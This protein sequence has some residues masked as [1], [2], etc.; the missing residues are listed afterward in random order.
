MKKI[1]FVILSCM[2]IFSLGSIVSAKDTGNGSDEF[3]TGLEEMTDEELEA[4]H[5]TL[6]RIVDVK[7]NSIALSRL[8]EDEIL[9][10]ENI[11]VAELGEEMVYAMPGEEINLMS[12]SNDSWLDEAVDVSKAATFPPIG[13]QG[14]FA[15][16]L[17]WTLCY[18]QLT[19]NN[20][21]VNGLRAKTEFGEAIPEN[22]MAPGFIFTL[23]NGGRNSGANF[24]YGLNAIMSFGC[25][26]ISHY[27]LEIT[28]E[29]LKKWC[30][31]TSV[32]YNAIYNRP[33]KFSFD[34]ISTSGIVNAK[35]DCVKNIKKIISNGYVVS[36]GTVAKA[37]EF[38]GN[39]INGEYACRYMNSQKIEENEGHAMTVVGYDDNYWVDVNGN[40]KEDPG[41]IGAFKIAN[42]WGFDSAQYPQGYAWIAYD[43]LGD[44]SGVANAPTNR[45]GAMG[46]YYYFIEPQKNYAPLLVA[47]LELTAMYRDNVGI[48]F[49]VS[50]IDNNLAA[51]NPVSYNGMNMPFYFATYYKTSGNVNFSGLENQQETVKIPFDLTPLIK[52]T[53]KNKEI[54]PTKDLKVSV[55]VYDE[56]S[57]M[58]TVMLGY[59]KILEPITGKKVTCLDA[60][61]IV[62]GG[63]GAYKCV[64]FEIT[65]IVSF[66]NQKSVVII[67]NSNICKESVEGNIDVITPD[68]E[69]ICPKYEVAG[70]EIIL[71]A[72]SGGYDYDSKYEIHISENINSIG[73]N[74][75]NFENKIPVYIHSEYFEFKYIN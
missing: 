16:C 34:E 48:E 2:I 15:S 35:S 22:I 31:D 7:P 70:K 51:T 47:E 27:E 8:S 69:I 4:F 12:A 32:W 66:D 20:C 49:K 29:S 37:F 67:F 6:P 62:A 18:Y 9:L 56:S 36:F 28:N 68:G 19:N 24:E 38:T 73:G 33:A 39:P 42:S 14:D 65:P 58:F 61:D 44:V 3:Y 50:D 71:F 72:P 54:S 21:V 46:Q 60:S 75:L 25:P 43:A 10:L 5:S 53:Y 17:T 63:D 11:E 23:L 55:Y 57:G 59:V 40:Q 45:I 64:D 1:I 41:E 13:N 74:G 30:T 52:M 26:D